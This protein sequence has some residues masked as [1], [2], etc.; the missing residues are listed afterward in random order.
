MS[1]QLERAL[2]AARK[3]NAKAADLE[4]HAKLVELSVQQTKQLRAK[5]YRDAEET[6]VEINILLQ[7][8]PASMRESAEGSE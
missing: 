3:A 2:E 4:R 1:R 5:A 6:N 7:E 8:R